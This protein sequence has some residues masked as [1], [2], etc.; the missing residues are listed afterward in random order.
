MQGEDAPARA[1]PEGEISNSCEAE[2]VIAKLVEWAE[3]P[4]LMERNPV[5]VLP[6]GVR[7]PGV[8]LRW[9][10]GK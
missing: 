4:R 1:R 9:K 10:S 2:R 5:R 8:S 6:R 3:Y 7:S